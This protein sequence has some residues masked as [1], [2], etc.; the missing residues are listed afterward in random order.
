MEATQTIRFNWAKITTDEFAVVEKYDPAVATDITI[1]F[2][3]DAEPDDRLV[4]VQVKGVFS[5][6]EKVYLV[7]AVTCFFVI[8]PED[9]VTLHDK[10]QKAVTLDVPLTLH[11]ASLSL[12]TFRGV[13]H[14]KTESLPINTVVLPL[15]NVAEIVKKK[16]LIGDVE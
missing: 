2:G 11:L 6:Q 7:L 9:W 5:Q 14:A 16:V 3:F 10:E 1:H 15:I 4:A 8:S 13:L 12:S